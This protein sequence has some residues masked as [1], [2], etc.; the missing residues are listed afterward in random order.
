MKEEYE[1]FGREWAAEIKKANKDFIINMAAKLGKER[2]VLKEELQIWR[3]IFN[4]PEDESIDKVVKQLKELQ[5]LKEEYD[6][7]NDKVEFLKDQNFDIDKY[8][9]KLQKELQA[10]K[11]EVRK[12]IYQKEDNYPKLKTLIK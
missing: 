12:Y 11:K 2:D 10:L 4:T 8:C 3:N 6:G 1:P 5:N 7:L 9:E